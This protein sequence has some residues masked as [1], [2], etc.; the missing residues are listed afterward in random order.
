MVCIK[1]THTHNTKL[2]LCH[3]FSHEI[4]ATE[5]PNDRASSEILEELLCADTRSRVHR[6]LHFADLFVDILHK[7]DDEIHQLVLVH[8]L[9]VEVGDQ[10]AD[11]V[12]LHGFPTKNKEVVRSHHH[13]AHKLMAQNLLNFVSLLNSNTDS[14]R[15]DRSLDENLLLL[16]SANNHRGQQQFLAAP[17][18]HFWLVVPLHNLR[19]EVLKAHRC[20]DG[21]SHRIEVWLQSSCHRCSLLPRPVQ[22]PRLSPKVLSAQTAVVVRWNWPKRMRR[23]LPWQ[24]FCT[25][26]RSRHFAHVHVHA[27]LRMRARV[28][29]L[30]W[31]IKMACTGASAA[32][33]EARE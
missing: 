29:V 31:R 19:R 7:L 5:S 2:F 20:C 9:S 22:R 33:S 13:K 24:Q 21:R 18:F 32:A 3:T 17:H 15:I 23:K 12:A 16:V 14:K 28:Q 11:V 10:E 25:N 1:H 30:S 4:T 6:Q 27:C 26:L 8:L